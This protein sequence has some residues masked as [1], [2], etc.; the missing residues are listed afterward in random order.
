[1]SSRGHSHG[2]LRHTTCPNTACRATLAIGTAESEFQHVVLPGGQ[3]I[4]GTFVAL[5][6]PRC[7]SVWRLNSTALRQLHAALKAQREEEAA[8]AADTTR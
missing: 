5:S 4:L 7:R 2:H 1:M 8:P 6:C 3:T